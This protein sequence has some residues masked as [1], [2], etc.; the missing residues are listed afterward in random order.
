MVSVDRAVRMLQQGV[1]EVRSALADRRPAGAAYARVERLVAASQRIEWVRRP[2]V[3]GSDL[4]VV[5]LEGDAPPQLNADAT[6]QA[7]R[8]TDGRV[9]VYVRRRPYTSAWAAMSLFHELDHVLDH[10]EGVWLSPDN[11][12]ESDW[13]AGEARAYHREALLIDTV[14][15]EGRLLPALDSLADQG[16]NQLLGRD[17]D[18]VGGT[19]YADVVPPRRRHRQGDYERGARNVALAFAAVLATAA[20]PGRLDKV[21]DLSA[22]GRDLRRAAERW[23]FS[24]V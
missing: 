14:I 1:E 23:G 9:R 12:S 2:V 19:L 6:F 5:V 7:N 21:E 22:H 3:G 4:Q 24:G 15:A 13:W 20:K 17:S 11:I 8:D 10:L 18:D 16:L